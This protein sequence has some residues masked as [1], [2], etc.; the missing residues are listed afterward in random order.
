MYLST[1]KFIKISSKVRAEVTGISNLH[2]KT[3]VFLLIQILAKGN[4]EKFAYFRNVGTFSQTWKAPRLSVR[5]QLYE[6]Q[7]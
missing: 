1:D 7:G 6:W 4:R 5:E 2:Y 3:V